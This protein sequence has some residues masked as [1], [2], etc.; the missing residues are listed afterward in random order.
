VLYEDLSLEIFGIDAAKG[1]L[2]TLERH[3]PEYRKQ[4]F[5][6]RAIGTLCEFA[7][8]MRALDRTPEFQK[9]A[10]VFDGEQAQ[11]WNDARAFFAQNELMIKKIRN[12][13]GGHFGENASRYALKQVDPETSASLTREFDAERSWRVTVGFAGVLAAAALLRHA[14]GADAEKKAQFVVEL[15]KSALPHATD[16]VFGVF[17]PLLWHNL[18]K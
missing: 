15:L 9:L 14:P 7:E 8:S 2:P 13:V 16:V 3:S 17:A 6:R 4:Y 11:A 5:A 18:G 12:D 10:Q 1:S